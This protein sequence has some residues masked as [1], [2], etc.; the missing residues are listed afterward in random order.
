MLQERAAKA[1]ARPILHDAICILYTLEPHA[2]A[3]QADRISALRRG[4]AE[5]QDSIWGNNS[6][7]E[8]HH[9]ITQ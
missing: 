8:I 6:I 1:L 5:L 4:L 7:T 3:E 2:D 9:G